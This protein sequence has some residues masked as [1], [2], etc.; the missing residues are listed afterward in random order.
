MIGW[1]YALYH[2]YSPVGRPKWPFRNT[3]PLL[4]L[5]RPERPKPVSNTAN[6]YVCKYRAPSSYIVPLYRPANKMS[7]RVKKTK[8]KSKVKAAERAALLSTILRSASIMTTP[9]SYC[10]SRGLDCKIA[11]SVSSSYSIYVQNH[12][13]FCDT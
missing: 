8:P 5:F 9:C 13:S 12:Q 4:E 2:A 1:H 6:S 10:K 7:S 3:I 11:L